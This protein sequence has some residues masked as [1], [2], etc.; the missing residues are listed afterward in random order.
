[1]T[2]LAAGVAHELNNPLAYVTANLAFLAE[3][4]ARLAALLSGAPPTA[5]D[6]DARGCSSQR[7]DARGAVSGAER[8]R[9]VV[10]DLKTFARAT[11]SAAGPVDVRRCS[12]PAVNMAWNEIRRRARLVRDLGRSRRCTATRRGSRR[13]S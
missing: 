1:M 12:T 11:T 6:A 10:R 7:R 2:A 13:C 8:M 3:R 9:A 5:D 4:P